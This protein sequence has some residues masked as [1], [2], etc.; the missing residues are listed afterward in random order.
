MQQS[1]DSRKGLRLL[2]AHLAIPPHDLAGSNQEIVERS[3][4]AD[5]AFLNHFTQQSR[6]SRK[7]IDRKPTGTLHGRSNQEIV[8]RFGKAVP[9]LS[10]GPT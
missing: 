4:Y 7:E 5:V 9:F 1:R 6:D 2:P 8:E 3:M 10:F